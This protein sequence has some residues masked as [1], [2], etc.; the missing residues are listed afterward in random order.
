MTGIWIRR[1]LLA[2]TALAPIP[3][4]AQTARETELEARLN[5]LEDSVRELRSELAEARAPAHPANVASAPVPSPDGFTVGG[6]TVKI[7]GFFKTWGSVSRYDGGDIAPNSVGRDFYV[8]GAIPVGGRSQGESFEA[9]V[10]QTRLV[11]GVSTPIANHVLKGLVELDFQVSPGAGN[12]RMTNAYNPGL[13]RAFIALDNVLIGQEW[14]NF[15]YLGA[16]PET[17]DFLGPSEGTVFV[18]QVQLRYTKPLA[19]GLTLSVAAENPAT[20]TFASGST[21]LVENGNDRVPDATARLNYTGSFGELSLAG[22]TRMLTVDTGVASDNAFGWGV[23]AA[24]KLTFGPGKRSD[25]RF[26]ATY[27]EG[28]GRYVGLNLAPDAIVTSTGGARLNPVQVAAGFA[29]LKFGWTSRLRS[30]VMASAQRIHYPAG[31]AVDGATKAAWSV[32]ANLFYSPVR[33]VDL[34]IEIRHG[35]RELMSGAKG[36]LDRAEIAAKYSF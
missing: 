21:T 23:S 29:A 6:T 4:A 27:G 35:E 5:V 7:N 31:L 20:T 25:L 26:M 8:P 1:A 3:A 15:Q 2:A 28:I 17:T 18:R 12:Q 36:Q 14:T 10:K 16:L 24:G 11:I 22:V 30:T 34:G 19:H 32:A 9:S 13:R 33:S